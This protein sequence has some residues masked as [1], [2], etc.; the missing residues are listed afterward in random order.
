MT[1]RQ[2]I[3]ECKKLWRAVLDGRAKDKDEA[4]DLFE[5]EKYTYGCPFCEYSI[6]KGVLI[7]SLPEACQSMNVCPLVQQTGWHCFYANKRA[8]DTHPKDF[9]AIIMALKD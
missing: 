1:K 8:Y 7:G 9:A 5:F 4:L 6:R 3:R 2:A